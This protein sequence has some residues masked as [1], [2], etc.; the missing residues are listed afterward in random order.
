MIK[1]FFILFLTIIFILFLIGTV[2]LLEKN[3]LIPNFNLFRAQLNQKNILSNP[4]SGEKEE[5]T[6]MRQGEEK[7]F[8]QEEIDDLLEKIDFLSAKILILQKE[9]EQLMKTINKKNEGHQEKEIIEEEINTEE[10]KEDEVKEEE[11]KEKNF[12][13]QEPEEKICQITS[14]MLP[15]K[16]KVIFNEIAWMGSEK[17]TNNEWIELKNL[18]GKEIDLTGWRIQNRDQK[19]KIIFPKG[20]FSLFSVNNLMILERTSDETIPAVKA[21]LIYTGALKNENEALYLFDENCQLQ[22]FVEANPYW[23]AGDNLT[24]RT[25][26][27]KLDLT[28]QTSLNFGGTPKRENSP[29][30]VEIVSSGRKSESIKTS[31]TY[32]KILISEVQISPI[33]DRF[34]ELYN[35]NSQDINLTNWYLQRKTAHAV[36]WNSF[37]SS[38]KFEEKIIYSKSH[39]LIASSSDADII[40]SLTLSEDNSL[41]L[42]NPSGEIVDLIGWGQAPE[43]ETSPIANPLLGKTLSRKWDENNQIY[44]DTDNNSTDFE[45]QSPSPKNKNQNQEIIN[46]PPIANFIFFPQNTFSDELILFDASFSSDSD[47][48][49]LEYLWDFGDGTIITSTQATTTYSY[50]GL[51]NEYLVQ[52]QIT[53]DKGATSSTS[54]AIKITT[55]KFAENII[56]T[57]VLFL[58]NQEFVEIYNPTNEEIFIGNWYISYFSSSKNWNEPSYNKPFPPATTIPAKSYFLIGFGDYQDSKMDWKAD[59]RNLS[60]TAGAIGIFSCNPAYSITTNPV[61]IEEVKNCKIDVLGWGE[62]IVNE[63]QPFINSFSDNKSLTRK[64]LIDFDNYLLYFDTNNNQKDFEIQESTPK[65][66]KNYP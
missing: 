5:L 16:N 14:E 13:E 60:N 37:V 62:T 51:K 10:E 40:L 32:P 9:K 6:Y 24:K 55:P 47:G 21:D 11:L 26:E 56:I 28:W 57:E 17:S 15:L 34:V 43:Y 39:F 29:G 33:Q 50:S 52:L 58:G 23:P 12:T 48:F 1:N 18:S 20:T 27:R 66:G 46:Q 53:D 65:T 3:F 42:K 41:A 45:I 44:Q 7:D 64:S 8:H 35:P 36:S 2:F 22:D 25:M 38:T 19:I 49:I 54:T 30:Y 31:S 61:S 59:N 63:N 4:L